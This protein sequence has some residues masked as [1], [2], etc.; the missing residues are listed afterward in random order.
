MKIKKVITSS[1]LSCAI[2]VGAASVAGAADYNYDA[3][4]FTYGIYLGGGNGKTFK[5]GG[6]QWYS[7]TQKSYYSGG[8]TGV[9]YQV[10]STSGAVEKVSWKHGAGTINTGTA[11]NGP[12]G[13]KKGYLRNAYNE[14]TPQTASGK[15]YY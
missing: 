13:N 6:R 8:A 1:I 3:T 5:L 12:K 2:L 10:R 14:A 9:G 7:G 15:F 4:H 11:L